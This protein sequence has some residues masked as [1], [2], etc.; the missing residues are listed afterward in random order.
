MLEDLKRHG[1]TI[2]PYH[3]A[4]IRRVATLVGVAGIPVI[5]LRFTND[6]F[7]VPKLAL[8]LAVVA[9]GATALFVEMLQGGRFSTLREIA[10]PALALSVPLFFA[11][12]FSP[13]RWWALFGE[14]QRFQG[15][16][17]SLLAVGL[18]VLVAVTFAGD[19]ETPSRWLVIAGAIAGGYSVFQ[20]IGIDL[21]EWAQQFGGEVTVT[22]TLGNTNFSGGFLAIC[23]PIAIANWW[24]RRV[25]WTV[26]S[27]LFIAGGLLV[28]VSQ[29][30]WVAATAGVAFAAGLH[31][32]AR[33]SWSRILGA[34]LA[35]LLA[36]ASL[37]YV[38]KGIVEAADQQGASTVQLR[39][40]WWESAIEMTIDRPILGHG[41]NSF[42]VD[43]WDYRS[44]EESSA[45]GFD[46]SNDPHSGY[47][48]MSTGA[49]L[50]G[51]AGLVFAL[52]WALRRAWRG[53]AILLFG[54]AGGLVAYI[55]DIVATVDELA[56][57][58]SA[59]ACIGI[60]VACTSAPEAAA[61]SPAFAKSR[62]MKGKRKAQPRKAPLAHPIGVV[63]SIMVGAFA[64]IYAFAL[65]VADASVR[66][67]I[68]ALR[69]GKIEAGRNHFE[70]AISIWP[71]STYKH[72]YAFLLGQ[73][74][75]AREDDDL[76]QES[77][78]VFAYLDDFPDIPGLRDAGKTLASYVELDSEWLQPA[79]DRYERA[80]AIDPYNVSLTPEGTTV[81]LAARRY[82]EIVDLV[83]PVVDV[84][85]PK[86]PTLWTALARSYF[87]L[88]N[89]EQA[90]AALDKALALI[91]EDPATLELADEMGNP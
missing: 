84:L 64:V 18:G 72:N 46:F 83:A 53:S 74:A 61:N 29:A 4:R 79:A 27:A 33:I 54:A 23:L 35:A 62:A 6:P 82:E 26:M 22:S 59:W 58:S 41:P 45:Q 1:G 73:V 42:A 76:I 12:V 48:S 52:G 47:L 13:Y 20:Y 69:F 38:V 10:L 36:L 32:S 78:D 28:S 51:L 77:A 55:T 3:A 50:L 8:L 63:V 75:V 37:G 21:F 19:P 39:S 2:V 25:P 87:E 91:P 5:F 16:I 71:S 43:S 7:N 15:L 70:R 89:E 65:V 86:S 60:V 80:M 44:A 40:W 90:R 24:Q 14:Y 30:A 31:F 57:R 49:G 34:G 11:T 17:P 56:L 66:S 67:G 68:E 81:L 88:D 9:V 85:G